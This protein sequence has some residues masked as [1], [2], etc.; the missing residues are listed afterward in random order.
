MCASKF[1][2][3]ARASL[4]RVPRGAPLVSWE[5][6]EAAPALRLILTWTSYP[7]CCLSEERQV[8]LLLTRAEDNWS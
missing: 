2:L 8:I 7:F 5:S 6:K 3:D 4:W 1:A